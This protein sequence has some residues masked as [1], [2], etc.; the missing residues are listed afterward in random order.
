MNLDAR[1]VRL[2]IVGMHVGPDNPHLKPFAES[3]N[4]HQIE[5]IDRMIDH[6]LSTML[7]KIENVIK[8]KSRL[9]SVD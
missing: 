6:H 8:P 2:D 7:H 1:L 9:R 3:L 4:D 5:I